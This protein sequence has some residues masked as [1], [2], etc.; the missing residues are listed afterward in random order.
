MWNNKHS[1]VNKPVKAINKS[2]VDRW[3]RAGKEVV[4][5]TKLGKN[6]TLLLIL[7]MIVYFQNGKCIFTYQYKQT[8]KKLHIYSFVKATY[9]SKKLETH[10]Y[11]MIPFRKKKKKQVLISSPYEYMFLYV[12]AWTQEKVHTILLK[13]ARY[14]CEWVKAED[15]QMWG[16]NLLY[17]LQVGIY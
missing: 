13:L 14:M 11:G 4:T 16:D 7:N 9:C 6:K 1:V 3:I 8:T 2:F 17:L 5:T 15:K 12:S 10:V